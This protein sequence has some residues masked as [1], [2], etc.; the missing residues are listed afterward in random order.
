MFRK[1]GYTPALVIAA[2][3]AGASVVAL[4]GCGSTSAGTAAG[5]GAS[6]TASASQPASSS[7]S[8]GSS[9]PVTAATSAAGTATAQR[10]PE[11]NAGE[12]RIAYTNNAQIREGAL[13]GMSK[14]DNVVTFTNVGRTTCVIQGY[15]GVAALNSGGSQIAQA[16][17]TGQAVRPVYLQP[18]QVASA[19][20]SADTASCNS[21]ASVPGLLVTAPDQ[22][23]STKLGEF[24]ELCLA[25][26][27]IGPVA[28]GN[29]A[30]LQ[31]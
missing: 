7:G 29:A 3:A 4:T 14:T 5:S 1:A 9:A 31:L 17:R 19:L 16:A 24:G 22:Y 23:S 13:V 21:P 27:R 15:P 6:A 26:L 30:G 8:S 12:L 2:V 28:P 18:G 11:C 25:S 10:T 20:V